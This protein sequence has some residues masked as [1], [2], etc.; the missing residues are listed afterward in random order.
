MES[1]SINQPDC[2]TLRMQWLT[3]VCGLNVSAIQALPADA[4]WRRYFR[5]QTA[6]HSFILMDAPVT[7][8]CRSFIAIANALRGLSLKT[9]NIF[10]AD[11][12]QNFLLLS[13]FGDAT[14]L[15]SL[16]E[17]NASRLYE[18]AMLALIKMQQ[19]QHVPEY[20]L[21]FFTNEWMVN[22]WHWHQ[23]WFLHQL[24]SLPPV[25]AK[26]D[27]AYRLIVD[28]ALAQ[29]RRFMHRD[30]HS[31]NLMILQNDVGIL[32]FQDAFIGP[33]TYDLASLLRDCYI[34]WSPAQVRDWA[35]FYYQT[36]GLK[37]VDQTTF[38]RWFDWMSLQRHLKALFTFAR[39]QIRDQQSQYLQHV[40][41]TLSYVIAVSQPY[42]ELQA[43]HLYYQDV[44]LPAWKDFYPCAR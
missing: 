36:S 10:E 14:Y 2:E 40:S 39:K 32:D 15:T 7:E 9:P 41:R 6:H 33:L 27:Q 34:A 24:L 16:N 26:V 42:P 11:L 35:A 1:S 29:P 28:S 8:D 43:L 19:C 4:S 25:E 20:T 5:V 18:E 31:A 21:P 30:Y 3:H 38:L 13:D 12:N 44:V 23:D 37:E 22:E 17:K